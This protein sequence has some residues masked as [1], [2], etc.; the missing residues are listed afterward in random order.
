VS[1]LLP[2]FPLDVVLFPGMLLPLHIFEPRYKEMI[3][4]CVSMGSQFGVVR[5][6]KDGI[7]QIGC[8]ASVMTVAKTYEDGRMDIVTR[9]LRRFEILEINQERSFLRGS[10]GFLDDQPELAPERRGK[11]LELHRSLML[12]AASSQTTLPQLE[13][14]D[15][16]LSFFLLA[17][18]PVDL[19]FKQAM[20]AMPSEERRIATLIEYYEAII[21]KLA[22]A[23]TARKKSSGNG[24]IM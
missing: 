13:A 9:G 22:D 14:P 5:A 23:V 17:Q 7:A 6:V 3:G 1:E 12:L 4:E 19:D 21:P 8:T 24:H 10:V 20:L 15:E 16:Q 18:L 11:A 2:L